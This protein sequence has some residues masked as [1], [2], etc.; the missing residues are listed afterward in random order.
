MRKRSIWAAVIATAA[1]TAAPALAAAPTAFAAS[2]STTAASASSSIVDQ[3][4]AGLPA[5]RE[6]AEAGRV[7]LG[8]DDTPLR[9]RLLDVIDPTQYECPTDTPPVLAAITAGIQDWT[10]EQRLAA[11]YVI[12]FDIPMTEAVYLPTP[13]PYTFGAK[14]N[15]SKKATN[16]FANLRKFW[17]IKSNDI[18]LR[19]A[20]G[21]MLLT[22]ARVTKVF[23]TLYGQAA[24]V[25][26]NTAAFIAGQVNTAALKFGDHPAFTFNAYANSSE[27]VPTPGVGLVPDRV[28]LGDGVLDGF[29][30]VGLGDV[31]TQAIL[32]HEFG[33]HVQFEDGLFETTLP[34][35][36]A[37]RRTELMAD[38]FSAYFLTHRR[39][40]NMNWKRVHQF[41]QVFSQIGDCGF[42]DPGHHGT[43][44]Q[45]MKS[46]LW[47][48]GVAETARRQ[49]HI[50]PS[51][52]FATRFD[53]ILPYL[54]APDATPAPV[55]VS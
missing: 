17:D 29:N 42:S 11:T 13:G 14:G 9:S 44:N 47:G 36:E 52:T 31:A 19:P 51:L 1:L 26:A 4:V 35:P 23:T 15:F 54:V 25:S 41:T 27:G 30:L 6:A 37:T 28:V 8:L 7:R 5:A 53:L 48:Y 40:E 20:H 46:A 22:Q 2:S 16:T 12:L 10:M 49:G 50:L 43:P 39:G 38:A 32:G 24:D 18:Q 34:A 33:H 45:R 3:L 55:N 21:R